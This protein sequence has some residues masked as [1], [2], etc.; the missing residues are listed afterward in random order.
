MSRNTPKR[1]DHPDFWLISQAVIDNDAQADAKQGMDDILARTA[2][3]K[4]ALYVAEQRAMRMAAH[5]PFSGPATMA[6]FGSLWIDG[7]MAGARFQALKDRDAQTFKD[8]VEE[9]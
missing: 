3:P 5:L 1:P 7:F 8:D 9:A 4:S 6:V 2:D